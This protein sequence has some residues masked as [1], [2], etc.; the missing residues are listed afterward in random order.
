MCTFLP[1]A[2]MRLGEH[3]DHGRFL[4]FL[5][6]H[7]PEVTG[8]LGTLGGDVVVFCSV[9]LGVF[10]TDRTGIDVVTLTSGDSEL[11]TRVRPRLD[12]HV[13]VPSGDDGGLLD[14]PWGICVLQ[15]VRQT[16][17]LLPFQ[18]MES[19]GNLSFGKIEKAR[20]LGFHILGT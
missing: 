14:F 13:A 19:G 5:E 1:G 7:M 12:V 4:A 11:D 15:S 8:V 6:D 9:A 17:S 20:D 3:N 2:F 16:E 18:V 10:E